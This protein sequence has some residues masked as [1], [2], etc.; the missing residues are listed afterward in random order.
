MKVSNRHLLA[1]LAF[2][3]VFSSRP[4]NGAV[5]LNPGNN[6]QSIVNANANN[7]TFIFS[8][9]TYSKQS[10]VPKAGD[11][12]DGQ[13]VAILDGGNRTARAF[14]GT[15][16]NVTIK[17]LTIQHYSSTLQNAAV[18]CGSGNAWTVT[19]CIIQLN[20]SVGVKFG[21]NSR[22][23]N[24]Q[25]VSNGEEGFAGGGGGWLMKNNQINNNKPVEGK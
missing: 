12:F 4:V 25:L 13:S 18:D 22:I 16:T 20:A 1:V 23:V 11:V 19:N 14:G 6:I 3:W 21:N 10:I 24:N 7:T 9:G 5:T 2:A 15:A 8:A 17:N